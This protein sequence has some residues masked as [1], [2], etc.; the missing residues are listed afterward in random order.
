M[1]PEAIEWQSL[2]RVPPPSVAR[3]CDWGARVHLHQG[4]T[5]AQVLRFG[6][7]VSGRGRWTRDVEQ[8]K[9]LKSW[10]THRQTEQAGLRPSPCGKCPTVFLVVGDFQG[11]KGSVCLLREI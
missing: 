9:V 3:V 4:W 8:V 10:Q 6:P 1:G 5:E 7:W 2:R 11:F